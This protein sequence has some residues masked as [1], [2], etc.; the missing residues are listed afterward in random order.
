MNGINGNS[1]PLGKLG[2]STTPNP[3]P[4]ELLDNANIGMDV[5]I[6]EPLMRLS[7]A[8]CWSSVVWFVGTAVGSPSKNRQ[9]TPFEFFLSPKGRGV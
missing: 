6:P 9:A 5:Q 4:F 2:F 1:Q 3:T 8:V 7:G